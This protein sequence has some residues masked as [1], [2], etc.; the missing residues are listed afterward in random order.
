MTAGAKWFMGQ[1]WQ[2]GLSREPAGAAVSKLPAA[3]TQR[4]EP[5]ALATARTLQVVQKLELKVEK[6]CAAQGEHI[7]PDPFGCS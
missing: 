6:L 2:V 7:Q 4:V 5:V 3:Q 1:A